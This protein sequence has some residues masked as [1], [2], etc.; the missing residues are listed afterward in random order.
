MAKIKLK[1]YSDLVDI[2]N[3]EAQEINKIWKDNDY[4]RDYK[5]QIGDISIEKQDIKFILFDKES[6][7]DNS[8]NDKIYEYY[9]K[10]NHLLSL[11]PRERAKEVAWG[12]FKLFYY[13]IYDKKSDESL[14]E[15]VILTAQKY[16]EENPKWS[17]PSFLI[18]FSLLGLSKNISMNGGVLRIIEKIEAREVEDIKSGEEYNKKIDEEEIKALENDEIKP[19]DLPF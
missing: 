1:T 10:R 9:K 2:S 16:F 13:G 17:K 4:E 8:H 5:L 3:Q 19:E 14:K 15:K 18:Y 11:T 7:Q 6:Q 12:H